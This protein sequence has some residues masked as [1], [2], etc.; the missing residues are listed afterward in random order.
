MD[1]PGLPTRQ[2]DQNKPVE[3]GHASEGRSGEG[4]ETALTHMKEIEQRRQDGA[5]DGAPS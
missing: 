2:D 3:H 1:K 4:A 5:V